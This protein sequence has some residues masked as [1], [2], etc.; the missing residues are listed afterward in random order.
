[1]TNNIKE[2]AKTSKKIIQFFEKEFGETGLDM[3]TLEKDFKIGFKERSNLTQILKAKNEKKKDV[4]F[5]YGCKYLYY[6]VWNE[7]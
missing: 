7:Q 5:A 2:D 1:M 6:R 3:P 4:K